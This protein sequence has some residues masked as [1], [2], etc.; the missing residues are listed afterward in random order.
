MGQLTKEPFRESCCDGG[1]QKD[2]E[3][4]AQPCGCDS[5]C[6]P[7][8]HLCNWHWEQQA[9]LEKDQAYK[10]AQKAREAVAAANMD[11][12][13]LV[14]ADLPYAVN[15]GSY[16][17]GKLVQSAP[18]GTG[19]APTR[20]TTLPTDGNARKEFP[21]ASGVLD[22]FPDALVAISNISKRGNDQHNP[23]QS[24]HWARGKSADEADTLMRHFLQR[25]TMDSDGTRHSAKVAWRA[26]ALLQKEI[27]AEKAPTG[28]P[29]FP[30]VTAK[31]L[32]SGQLLHRLCG[33]CCPGY[34]YACSLAYGHKADHFAYH[35]NDIQGQL[36]FR[37]RREL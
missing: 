2:N 3:N 14:A 36:L 31:P 30:Q 26:L 4:S 33:A 28:Y 25:G 17:S 8:P 34:T 24:L 37:W 5:G 16:G 29:G 32:E 19:G 18:L 7:R 15:G 21:V 9:N 20:A 35:R 22:Y 6:K 11:C 23:G 13:K 10:R 12:N 1:A 27:E